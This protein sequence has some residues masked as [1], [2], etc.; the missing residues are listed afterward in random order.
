MIILFLKLL[1]QKKPC[2]KYDD[3]LETLITIGNE[4][5][6]QINKENADLYAYLTKN[7]GKV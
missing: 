3:L 2:P 4:E 5:I 1:A 7:T 6:Q